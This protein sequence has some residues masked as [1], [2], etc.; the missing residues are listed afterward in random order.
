MSDT[1]AL[2]VKFSSLD[3]LSPA[4]KLMAGLTKDA[5]GGLR[6]L[7]ADAK[8]L[9]GQMKD[10]KSRIGSV[11][12]ATREMIN[13][14]KR[15]AAAIAETDRKIAQSRRA[16]ART[17][18]AGKAAGQMR[19]SG[20]EN[21]AVGASIAAPLVLA[22][23][24]SMLFQDG[25][26]DIQLK[27]NLT[28]KE[29]AVMAGNIQA[30]ATKTA[31]LP[32]SIRAGVDVLAGFGM[33]PRQA[34]KAIG[35][36]A[37]VATAYSAEIDQV[38]AATY[39]NIDNLKVPIGQ[40]TRA[41]DVMANAGKNGAFELG[42]MAQFFPALTAAAQ[43]LGQKG[44]PAVADL[45][46]AAQIARKGAGSSDVAAN[47]LLNLLNKINSVDAAKNFKAFGIDLP[48]ALKK[49]YA[50]GKTPIEA[51]TE[52][53]SKALGG[54]MTKLSQLFQDQQVQAA[55]RPLVA[56]IG[57]YRRIRAEALNANGDVERDFT[58]RM[59]N[60]GAQWKILAEN[61]IVLANVI[62]STLL[63][64]VNELMKK[65]AGVANSVGAW[66]AQH[67]VLFGYIVKGIALFAGFAIGVGALRIGISFLL[68]PW[69]TLLNIAMKIGPLASAFTIL[70][71]GALAAARGVMG[72][73]VA[74]LTNPIVWIAI[75]IGLAALAIYNHWD[76]I[77]ATFNGAIAWLKSLT[78]KDV[79]MMLLKGLGEGM[80]MGIAPVLQIAY[81]LA[82]KIKSAF[83]GSM[84]IKSPSRVF[85]GY[86]SHIA[87]GLALGIENGQRRPL[88]AV[89]R[90]TTGLATAG[91]VGSAAVA[92]AGGSATRAASA[93]VTQNFYITQSA[94]EDSEALARRIA[95]LVERQS[96][97]SARSSYED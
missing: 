77:K 36:I 53:T 73:S 46:A 43:G 30:I 41:L 31:Q 16:A 80:L 14:E 65:A 33:D 92:S 23:R 94:G 81:T 3:K 5:S 18:N 10:L 49:A 56:N 78:L 4:L 24:Q 28:A 67:P 83:T 8:D 86:G 89:R 96:R 34:I 42:D 69:A 29:T 91:I 2:T 60:G 97:I 44:V 9:N 85:M 48:N 37:R 84:A 68:G 74:L 39:A 25:M 62:G 90:L 1:L 55:L 6:K 75:G 95:A 66:A 20:R 82:S 26:T 63:P 51:I 52:L 64:P 32:E 47:N 88:Q 71:V 11:G 40:T 19:S 72:L 57:E 27:A 21:I 59:K 22:V 50:D 15:L 76:K 87:T 61:G 12:V 38:A 17:A 54:D 93:P 79:G 7:K 70:K 58:T 45:A 35:P 13:E